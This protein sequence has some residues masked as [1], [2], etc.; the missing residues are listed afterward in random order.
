MIGSAPKDCGCRWRKNASPPSCVTSPN[1]LFK[2]QAKFPKMALWESCSCRLTTGP[3][4]QSPTR[5]ERNEYVIAWGWW[6]DTGGELP[7]NALPQLTNETQ[8]NNLL[9]PWST[10][11]LTARPPPPCLQPTCHLMDVLT[12]FLSLCARNIYL[13]WSLALTRS[14]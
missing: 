7:S 9:A 2:A 14:Q 3:S 12:L 8:T 11:Q 6:S 1:F 5:A 13:L 4:G 10:P